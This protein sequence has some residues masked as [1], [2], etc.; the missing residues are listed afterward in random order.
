MSFP[1]V[2]DILYSSSLLLLSWPFIYF[3]QTVKFFFIFF[4]LFFSRWFGWALKRIVG[5]VF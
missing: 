2:I 3:K 5:G 4:Y 1:V